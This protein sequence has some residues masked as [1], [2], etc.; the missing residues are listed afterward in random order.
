MKRFILTAAAL[1][2]GF[3]SVSAAERLRVLI[4]H[5]SEYQREVTRLRGI[6]GI[7]VTGVTDPSAISATTLANFDVFYAGSCFYSHLDSKAQ[8]LENFL[9]NGGGIV[10]GQRNGGRIDWLPSGYEASGGTFYPQGGSFLLTPSGSAHPIFEGLDRSDLGSNPADTIYGTDLGPAWDV[11]MVHSSDQNIVGMAAGAYGDGRILLWPTHCASNG[12][13]NPSDQFIN[14]A[15][16]WV[17]TGTVSVDPDPVVPRRGSFQGLGDLPG[18]EYQSRAFAVSADGSAVV[19]YSASGSGEWEAFRWSG[20]EGMVPL[21][22]LPGRE[23]RSYALAVSADGSVV[24]GASSSAQGEEGGEAFRWTEAEGMVGLDIL[25][26]RAWD[27]SADGS[28][29]VG[30]SD[31]TP[32][33]E[34]QAFRWT[35]AEGMVSLGHLYEGKPRSEARGVSADGSVVVGFSWSPYPGFVD[36]EVFRWTQAEG[37]VGL[38]RLDDQGNSYAEGVSA[39]G[40]AVVGYSSS[41]LGLMEAFRWTAETEMAGLGDLPGN[42]FGSRAWAASADG[43]V[44]IGYGHSWL[45][46]EAFI[47]DADSGM[48]SLKDVLTNEYGLGPQLTGWTLC[49]PRGISDDGTVIVGY[50]I[51]PSGQTEAWR[52]VLIPEPA[53]LVLLATAAVG[54]LGL[55]WRKRKRNA[56]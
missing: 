46:G 47:W 14:Q 55:A 29:I 13:Y 9:R 54:L 30:C 19:G 25:N 42:D 51:N 49:G 50:G 38:G 43:S 26:S 7:S 6:Q 22:H 21:G 32:D 53:T 35:E 27:V 5:P 2:A 3:G 39:D 10:V 52:A 11:L 41:S 45:G 37:M 4:Y 17:A 16:Q 12:H 24:V 20:A 28:V 1:L 18:G 40:S 34:R 31:M 36:P 23:L 8:V 56:K 44:V 48:R 15:Y 33:E